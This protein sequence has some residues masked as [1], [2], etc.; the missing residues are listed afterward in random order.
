MRDGIAAVLDVVG[1]NGLAVGA[2]LFV[3]TFLASLA[4]TILV[5][6]RLPADHFAE[7]RRGF[8]EHRHPLLRAAG[9]VAKNGVGLLLVAAGMVMSIPGFPGQG[10]LTVLIGLTLVDFPGKRPLERALVR[11]PAIRRLLDRVRARFGRPALELDGI[12]G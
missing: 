12:D 4:L 3:V 2:S 1:A 5:V 6:V 9:L 10:V 8:W 11:R 7:H